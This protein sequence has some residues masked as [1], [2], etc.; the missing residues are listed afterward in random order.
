M[1]NVPTAQPPHAVQAGAFATVEASWTALRSG[2]LP[3]AQLRLCD[4]A[5]KDIYNG[6]SASTVMCQA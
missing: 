3:V 1:S 6:E 5:Q 2:P 4:V